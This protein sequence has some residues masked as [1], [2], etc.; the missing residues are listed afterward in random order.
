MTWV[1]VKEE[2]K[3]ERNVKEAREHGPVDDTVMVAQESEIGT[4]RMSKIEA[5]EAEED[6]SLKKSRKDDL[7]IKESAV[8]TGQH[9]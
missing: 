7:L 2:S 3:K 4:K 1:K 5:L 9:C 6:R 8:A